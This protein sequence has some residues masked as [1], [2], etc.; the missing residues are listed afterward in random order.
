MCFALRPCSFTDVRPVIPKLRYTVIG[1]VLET[2]LSLTSTTRNHPLPGPRFPK[3]F[4][5]TSL[6][7][8]RLHLWN[9]TFCDIL[10]KKIM[11]GVTLYGQRGNIKKTR[12]LPAGWWSITHTDRSTFKA[13][14]RVDLGLCICDGDVLWYWCRPDLGMEGYHRAHCI[15]GD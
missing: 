4:N 7:P 6:Q 2:L 11:D 15:C 14:G 12:G 5:T 13:F 8:F 1:H 3:N 9:L 10:A